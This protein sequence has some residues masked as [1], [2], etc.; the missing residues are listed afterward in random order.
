MVLLE[1]AS[2]PLRRDEERHRRRHRE[3]TSDLGE[4]QVVAGHQ[5]EPQP[6]DLE[7]LGGR[8]GTGLDPV[9]LPLAERVVQVQLPVGRD[10]ARGIHGDHGVAHAPLII[11]LLEQARHD[12][13]IVIGRHRPEAPR[14]WPDEVLGVR[15]ERLVE[16]VDEVARVL[17][18]DHDTGTPSGCCRGEVGD[19]RQVGLGRPRWV[20]TARRRWGEYCSSGARVRAPTAH[21][22]GCHHPQDRDEEAQYA[23]RRRGRHPC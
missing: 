12:D 10:D 2:D 23:L 16:R 9:G 17:R 5:P 14:E 15:A 19:E 1:R 13:D 22:D 6:A 11:R 7:R 3:Q 21:E 4:A 20:R 18:E 8:D